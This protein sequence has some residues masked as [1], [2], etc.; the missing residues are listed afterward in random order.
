[1]TYYTRGLAIAK[2]IGARD[3]ESNFYY[4]LS[5]I[6]KRKNDYKNSLECMERY[7]ALNDSLHGAESTSKIEQAQKSYEIGKKNK[8]VEQMHEAKVRAD[9]AKDRADEAYKRNLIF[10]IVG[11]ILLMGIIV[12]VIVAL[13][14][15]QK[16]N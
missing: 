16:H 7:V 1:M 15:K 14:N 5:I 9:E 8:E 4:E 10:S 2:R 12:V 6:Y 13:R 3:L 11:G